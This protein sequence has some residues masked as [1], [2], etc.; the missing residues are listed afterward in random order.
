MT[1]IY[2]TTNQTVTIEDLGSIAFTHPVTDYNLI[3]EFTAEEIRD[4]ADLQNAIDNSY[5]TI[6]DNNGNTL[7]ELSSQSIAINLSADGTLSSNSD[8]VAVSE[9]AIKTYSDTKVPKTTTINSKALSSNITLNSSDIGLSNVSND[10]QLKIAS[11]LSD[12]NNNV[13]A[14]TSLG[15]GDSAT[16][17]VGTIAGTVATGNHNHTGVYEA[18][19]SKN[20]AFNKDFGITAGTVCQGNDSRLDS[21]GTDTNAIHLNA[22]SE[23]NGLTSKTTPVDA[24]ITVIEDSAATNDKKKL[25]WAN[26]KATLKTYFDTL[27]QVILVSGTNIKTVDGTTLL[28]SGNVSIKFGES[29]SQSTNNSNINNNSNSGYTTNNLTVV[30]YTYTISA[31]NTGTYRIGTKFNFTTNST[32]SSAKF[33]WYLDGTALGDVVE[34]E[35]KDTSDD[36]TW[37]NFFYTTLTSGSHTLQL[38][39]A[40]ESTA[41]TQT[42]NSSSYEFWRVS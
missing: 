4:S 42:F 7:T 19:F 13:T 24:D 21:I 32:S 14:R 1:A 40:S 34:I 6:K 18:A 28:G 39:S 37:T 10:A 17:N 20:T 27:Y 15:L 16:L 33:R 29:F 36:I 2:L 12:L 22:S 30:I 31:T 3:T 23:I 8:L 11:N 25:T 26:I 38:R 41:V 35:S 5:I 9:K